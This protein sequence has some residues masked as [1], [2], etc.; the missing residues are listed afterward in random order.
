MLLLLLVLSSFVVAEGSEITASFSVGVVEEGRD[1]VSPPSFW[2]VYGSYIIGLI[3]VLIIVKIVYL[4]NRKAKKKVK[5]RKVSKKKV[6]RK[7]G[8][9]K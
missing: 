8:K 1:Y 6:A 3:V 2:D 4:L 9:K 5:H 7:K